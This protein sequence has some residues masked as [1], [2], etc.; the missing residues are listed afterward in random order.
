[1]KVNVKLQHRLISTQNCQAIRLESQQLDNRPNFAILELTVIK[2]SLIWTFHVNGQIFTPCLL[3]ISK[4][5][6]A[7]SVPL[8]QSTDRQTTENDSW[9]TMGTVP[10]ARFKIPNELLVFLASTVTSSGRFPWTYSS[11]G[12]EDRIYRA[13]SGPHSAAPAWSSPASR[14]PGYPAAPAPEVGPWSDAG[15]ADTCP[16]AARI[17]YRNLC[18]KKSTNFIETNL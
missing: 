7:N 5:Y 9:L 1:M 8:Y 18:G 6:I 3:I 11:L 14:T 4:Q 15:R 10:E 2:F 17:S 13:G 16:V 12:G